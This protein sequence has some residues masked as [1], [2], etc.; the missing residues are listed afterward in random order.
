MKK[1]K[2]NKLL[3]AYYQGIIDEWDEAEELTRELEQHIADI[4]KLS[5]EFDKMEDN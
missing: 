4:A 1:T 5:K 3:E 2:N